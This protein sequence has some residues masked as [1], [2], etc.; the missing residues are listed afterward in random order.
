ML[1]LYPKRVTIIEQDR[2]VGA[3]EEDSP[4]VLHL[5]LPA[6]TLTSGAVIT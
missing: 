1:K 3:L 4:L 2:V 5:V 6:D